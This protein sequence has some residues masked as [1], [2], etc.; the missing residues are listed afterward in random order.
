MA[1][2]LFRKKEKEVINSD[3]NE[4]TNDILDDFGSFVDRKTTTGKAIIENEENNQSI[5]SFEM[6]FSENVSNNSFNNDYSNNLNNTEPLNLSNNFEASYTEEINNELNTS[7]LNQVEVNSNIETV[8]PFNPYLNNTETYDDIKNEDVEIDN[9]SILNQN[10]IQNDTINNLNEISN[11]IKNSQDI[12]VALSNLYGNKDNNNDTISL[13]NTSDE[14]QDNYN[15]EPK[16]EENYSEPTISMPVYKNPY[17][18]SDVD[19]GYKLC[20]KC[21]Q[22]IREDY[23][24]CFVCGT[25]F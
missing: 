2:N 15:I 7:S 3:N 25:V 6:N 22:K 24:Q 4:P 1:F 21:G 19:P 11:N 23:K 14:K 8:Q 10:I 20:P 5:S 18:Y 16:I 12:N 9:Q 13:K 17:Q